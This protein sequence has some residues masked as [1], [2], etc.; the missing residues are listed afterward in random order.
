MRTEIV[1]PFTDDPTSFALS[2]DGRQIVF[3]A[4]DDGTPRLCLR[5]LA[6]TTAQP[7]AGNVHGSPTF[8][9]DGRRFLFYIGGQ[10]RSW[11]LFGNARQHRP[12][13][14]D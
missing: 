8:L 9:P 5:S 3:A 10:G 14:A 11:D 7:L 13:A 1:T 12:D 4:S 6:S 2:P